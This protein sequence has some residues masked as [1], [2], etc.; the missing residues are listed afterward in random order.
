M[1]GGRGNPDPT[2]L[3]PYQFKKGQSGNPGGR[4]AISK[5]I[6]HFAQQH[7]EECIRIL[8]DIARDSAIAPK[9]RIEAIKELNNRS[10]GKATEHIQTEISVL[11]AMDYSKLSDKELRQMEELCTKAAVEPLLRSREDEAVAELAEHSEIKDAEVVEKKEEI[12]ITKTE[13]PSSK[14]P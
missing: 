9:D 14:L 3:K 12:E 4:S 11:N 10:S 13:D 8:I 1:A 7:T 5:T 2:Q 6:R